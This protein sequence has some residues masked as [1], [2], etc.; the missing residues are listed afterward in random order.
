MV[1]SDNKVVLGVVYVVVLGGDHSPIG[2]LIG[3]T[4]VYKHYDNGIGL[5][6]WTCSAICVLICE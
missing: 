6:L 3:C 4:T 1:P 5:G 2:F